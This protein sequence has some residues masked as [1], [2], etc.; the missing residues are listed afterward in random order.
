V[1]GCLIEEVFPEFICLCMKIYHVC[2]KIVLLCRSKIGTQRSLG[3]PKETFS[4]CT[5]T[6]SP[7]YRNLCGTVL[8]GPSVHRV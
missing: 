7:P 4:A 2:K 5:E 1:Y 6:Y 3:L 8:F